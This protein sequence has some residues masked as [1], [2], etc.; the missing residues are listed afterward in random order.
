[1]TDDP[2][3]SMLVECAVEAEADFIIS[4]DDDLIRLRKFRNIC[5]VS[6]NEFLEK[7]C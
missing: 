7:H 5:V 4:G 3:D 1:M 6:V 2:K